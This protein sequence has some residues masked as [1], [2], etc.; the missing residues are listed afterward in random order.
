[1]T[2]IVLIIGIPFIAGQIVNTSGFRKIQGNAVAEFE[3]KAVTILT[4]EFS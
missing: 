1:M 4:I 2:I 3:A